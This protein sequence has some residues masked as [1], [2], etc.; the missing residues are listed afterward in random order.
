MADIVIAILL[1]VIGLLT[2]IIAPAVVKSRRPYGVAGDII[3][4]VLVLVVLGMV[5]WLWLLPA[6]GIKGPLA[7]AAT[8]GDPWAGALIAL[9]LMRKVKPAP[10]VEPDF[11]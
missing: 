8:I 10:P 9:W 7:I 11:D 6:L 4:S 5:G 2:G 1:F 3:V